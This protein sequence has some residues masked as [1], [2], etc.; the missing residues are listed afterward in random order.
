MPDPDRRAPW[1]VYGIAV[2]LLGYI[3]LN[4][5]AE[6]FGPEPLG[7][8]LRF[9]NDGAV[10]VWVAPGFPAARVGIET[11]DV[12]VA[13]GERSLRTLFHWRALLEN[14][15][16]AHPFTL[17]VTRT[18][19]RRE[20]SLELGPN[21]RIWRAGNWV[22]L[23]VKLAAQL[24]TLGLALLI[25]IRRHRERVAL[26]GALFLSSLAVTN[27]IPVIAVDPHAPSLP[28]GAAAIWEAL[29]LWLGAPLWLGFLVFSAG[30][31]AQVQFF[32]EFPK[33]AFRTAR[34]WR[35]WAL[36]WS[37]IVVVGMPG[38][39]YY[40]YLGVYNP[41]GIDA[42]LPDW[43]TMFIGV[44][45]LAA[46]CVGMAL[47]VRSFRRLADRNEQR[48]LRVLVAGAIAGLAGMVPVS[49]AGFFNLPAWVSE[50]LRS[51]VAL[52][53]ANLLFLVLPASFAYAVLR[54]QVFDIGFILR[55][56]LQY[57]L[58]RRLV[59]SLVP[60][61]AA[62]LA[63]DLFVHG[64]QPFR[65]IVLSRG[66]IYAVV[67]A[68]ALAAHYRRHRWL[69][70]IDRRF[71]RERYD[72]QRLLSQVVEE[73]RQAKSLQGVATEV[74][75]HVAAALH[76]QYVA[77]LVGEPRELAYRVL[78]SVPAEGIHLSLPRDS[79]LAALARLLGKPLE[80]GSGQ[81]SSIG[82]N[83]PSEEGEF[84]RQSGLGLIVTVATPVEGTEALLALGAKRS[85]EPYSG[86]DQQLL[87]A[88]AA[89]LGLL[90]E[91]PGPRE[92]ADSFTECPDCGTC[93]TAGVAACARDGSPLTEI[94]LPRVLAAR[95]R[96]DRRLGRGGMGTVYEA[97]D[98]E[99]G[100][101]VAVKVIREEL[102]GSPAAADRFRLEARAA[103]GFSHPNVV[104]VHDFGVVRDTR[105][106]LVMELLRGS[107]LRDVL[108]R[109]K[110][111]A[112]A[113]AVAILRDLASAVDAAHARHLV[114]RDLKPENVFLA[115]DDADAQVKL[116]DFGVAKFLA[117]EGEAETA[118]GTAPGQ[119]VGTV[120]YMGPEQLRGSAA[121]IGCD[122][123][124]IAVMAYEM[125][126]GALPFEGSTAADYQ[127][128]V[129]SGRL[130]PIQS[131]LTEAPA[132]LQEFFAGA[133]A[134][135]P[136]RRSGRAPSLVA[137]LEVALA[138]V[139]PAPA[140]S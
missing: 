88:I 103:A 120:H 39:L 53:G 47:L 36:A 59:V 78:A 80:L 86:E 40:G 37:P 94:R 128:S 106:F 110:R 83:L 125:L 98:L 135:E 31:L 114:H 24:V 139:P 52:A 55:Q 76:P 16:V 132:R 133:L 41:G 96:L 46:V 23:G 71:F 105:A 116:L 101:R 3:L 92:P 33:P 122:L 107:S 58:A 89:S 43:F 140:S 2:C 108:R 51:P 10:V 60:A 109:E 67:A 73:I 79:K 4:A 6:V 126:A 7:T 137:D 18:G 112:P 48:R 50:A 35:I 28:A 111:L 21:W 124:A 85:E 90:I 5:Y 49:M 68:A 95:Y 20:V 29:P 118:V 77:V 99:L 12:I 138:I 130:T 102:V 93:D 117:G 129:L 64:D 91:R 56:G 30:P 84:V 62:V 45:V 44:C 72:A 127:S 70:A 66:W 22:T 26:V 115:G 32:A 121:G 97:A 1:W 11:G 54:H 34:A 13:A 113:R 82:R 81:S 14:L 75:R 119:V 57:A 100:R 104:V 38:L 63:I 27:F 74:V 15:E 136:A 87:G 42:G 131:H 9:R 123:W 61:C 17:E 19:H 25:A 65:S 69:E 134:L 8:D